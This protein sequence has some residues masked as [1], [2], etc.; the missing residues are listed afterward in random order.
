[1]E[2]ESNPR[3]VFI[4]GP[5]KE[6]TFVLPGGEISVGR[7]ASNVL[8]IPDPSVSRR[9]CLILSDEHGFKIR[10]LNSR[11]GTLVNGTPVREHHLSHSDQIMKP[12]GMN[13]CG[14]PNWLQSSNAGICF[15]PV[16]NSPW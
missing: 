6:S 8:A 12:P 15:S 11:N 5:V 3:L 10:D 2:V 9:H 14:Y 13:D 16:R 7:D 4:G 1:M